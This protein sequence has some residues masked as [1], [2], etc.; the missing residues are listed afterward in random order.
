MSINHKQKTN[1]DNMLLPNYSKQ[2]NYKK[3]STKHKGDINL[4]QES[5]SL[6]LGLVREH[7][8]S[9]KLRPT[10][11]DTTSLADRYRRHSICWD[12]FMRTTQIQDVIISFFIFLLISFSNLSLILLSITEDSSRHNL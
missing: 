6:Q 2:Q 1:L 3:L 12:V 5:N 11:A 8:T 9:P 4:K 7:R 10:V